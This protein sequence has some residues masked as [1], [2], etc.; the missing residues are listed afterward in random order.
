MQREC[1]L[2]VCGSAIVGVGSPG[3]PGGFPGGEGAPHGHEPWRK[4]CPHHTGEASQSVWELTTKGGMK[5]PHNDIY[6]DPTGGPAA[7]DPPA[8]SRSGQEWYYR[9][10]W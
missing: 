6:M 5:S 3:H 8:K 1:V 9:L 7:E 4:G 10:P 2:E